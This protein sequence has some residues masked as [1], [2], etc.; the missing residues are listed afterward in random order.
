MILVCCAVA[1]IVTE[2]AARRR[3]MH[4]TEEEMKSEAPGSVRAARQLV[5]VANPITAEGI[6]K[7]AMLMRHASNR[8]PV[9]ALFVRNDDEQSTR[10]VGKAALS[11]A[12]KAAVAADIAVND[13]ER[14]DIN[15]VS[16]IINVAI[17][18]EAT[19]IVI[20]L[21]RK[22]N[23]VD[24][25]YGSLIDSLLGATNRMVIMSRCF[26][27]VN[28]VR[29]LMVIVPPKAEYETGFREWV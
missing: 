19:D 25:F 28:T 2:Q 21:H 6:M 22:S 12:V 17:E 20:G 4:I 7:L 18:R 13:V 11:E 9:T 24:T 14:Y 8:T 15:I 5:A 27:P 26:I 3:R 1:S 23:I 16:G 29:S 10:A